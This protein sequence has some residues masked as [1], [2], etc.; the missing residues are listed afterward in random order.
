MH[1][2]MIT[3]ET[4]AERRYGIGRSLGPLTDEL[5]RRGITVDYIC[6]S[7]L[8]RRAGAMMLSL[9]RRLSASRLRDK[10][11]T[12]WPT[13]AYILIERMNMGRLA[14]KLAAQRH[15]THVHCHDPIIAAGFRLFSL[16]RPGARSARW[17]ITE[18]GFGCYMNAIYEDGIRIGP[19]AMR[20]LRRWE[21]AILRAADWVVAPTHS[22]LQRI[23][24][25]LD[26][27]PLPS[28]WHTIYHAR[29]AINRYPK[30]EART[31]LGWEHERLY[32][33]AIGRIAPVKQFPML[34]EACSRSAHAEHLQ[35]FILGEG[36]WTGLQTL[37][38]ELG[39]RRD[40]GFATTDDVGLYLSAA[41]V[42]VSTSTSESFGLA[43]LEALTAGI[44]SICTAVGGV[45][46]VVDNGA[47]LIPPTLD[48]L[49][50]SLHS[51]LDDAALRQT[52]AVKG[53]ARADA[54][55]TLSEIADHYEALYR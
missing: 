40:I 27:A 24:D 52:V 33:L 47:M 14:A 22:A 9:Y 34:V 54:W 4:A 39:L 49:T 12:D 5:T 38:R 15:A 16:F 51:L 32:V 26:V 20:L 55:P 7:D 6:Q 46:E 44:A 31:R 17:G 35:L 11:T 28:H 19:T 37:G 25:D 10:G 29:P 36:D 23:A 42:Y 45:P 53:Q 13:L 3:R 2:L 30:T 18:H 21:A 41:D 1:I 43:N 48:N 8:G 50:E